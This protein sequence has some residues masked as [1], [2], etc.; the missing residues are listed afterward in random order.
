MQ[1]FGEDVRKSAASRSGRVD[2]VPA[3]P[4]RARTHETVPS[5]PSVQSS[6]T[7]VRDAALWCKYPQVGLH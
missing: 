2:A 4:R 6:V 3:K 1:R 5:P 7:A